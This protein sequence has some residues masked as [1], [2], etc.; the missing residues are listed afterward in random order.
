MSINWGWVAV[1][2]IVAIVL[3]VVFGMWHQP[4]YWFRVP[5]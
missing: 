3:A 2:V 1:A 4:S 5:P